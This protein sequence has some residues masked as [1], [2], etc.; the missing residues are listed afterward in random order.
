MRNPFADYKTLLDIYS[1]DEQINEIIQK[2]NELANEKQHAN[3]IDRRY[4]RIKELKHMK[5]N[6][7]NRLQYL[8]E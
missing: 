2:I 4:E 1:Y 7:I 6:I 5:N 3:I 8:I